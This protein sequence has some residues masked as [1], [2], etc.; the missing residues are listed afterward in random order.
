MRTIAATVDENGDLLFLKSESTQVFCAL[1]ETHTR[2]A[3]HVEPD[4]LVLRLVFHAVRLLGFDAW[5]RTWN[6][7]WRV[8][9]SP[10][11]GPILEGRWRNRQDA[12]LAEIEFLNRFF[13]R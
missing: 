2:R 3:S 5:S 13:A 4:D 11:N 9:T 7:L 10:V 6:C 1:G 12:I 8:N